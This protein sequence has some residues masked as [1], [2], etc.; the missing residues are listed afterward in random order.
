MSQDIQF[1]QPVV[2]RMIIVMCGD[3][4]AASIISRM[5]HGRYVMDIHISWDNHDSG[6]MLSCRALNAIQAGNEAFNIRRM[7][8]YIMFFKIFFG[9]R[10]GC[11]RS[12]CGNG[13]GAADIVASE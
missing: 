12:N 7:C 13:A 8:R 6:R 10:P 1:Y 3:N 9:I 5:A 11:L 4:T 2:N